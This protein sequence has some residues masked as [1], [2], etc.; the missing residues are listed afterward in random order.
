MGPYDIPGWDSISSIQLI[1]NI[2]QQFNV[3]LS[4]E[5]IAEFDTI[6]DIRRIIESKGVVFK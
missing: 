2:E 6:G 5:D 4:I 1:L 3:A